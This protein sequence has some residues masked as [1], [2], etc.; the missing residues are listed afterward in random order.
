[1]LRR[2]LSTTAAILTLVPHLALAQQLGYGIAFGLS[3]SNTTLPTAGTGYAANDTITLACTQPSTYSPYLTFT[4]SPVIKVLTVSTGAVAT[5]SVTTQGAT[6]GTF[7]NTAVSCAQASTSGSGT[8]A[9]FTGQLVPVVG[10]TTQL[11][12]A[13][14]LPTLSTCGTG[15]P[16]ATAGSNSNAGQFTLGSGGTPTACTVTFAV[17]YATYAYCTVTPASSGGAAITGGYY[18]SAMSK[19]AFTLTIGTGTNSL[20][21]DYTCVGN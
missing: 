10:P 3:P 5:Y 9:T 14:N 12:A 15:S 11:S 18:L 13:A 19:T 20:V 17:P 1:M 16:V 2:L 4:T 8:G 6:N 21:F 7:S